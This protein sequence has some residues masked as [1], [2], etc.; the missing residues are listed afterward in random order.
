MVTLSCSTIRTL[1]ENNLKFEFY[2]ELGFNSELTL[3][4]SG[5]ETPL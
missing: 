5:I 3:T 2:R 1:V 4:D